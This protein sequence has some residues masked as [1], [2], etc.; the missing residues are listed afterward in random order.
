MKSVQAK[1]PLAASMSDIPPTI[2]VTLPSST[3]VNGEGQHFPGNFY[4]DPL[5]SLYAKL[6][7]AACS[8]RHL[9]ELT[10]NTR[11]H[12]NRTRFDAN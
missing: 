3:A 8:T 6:P 9:G 7:S 12:L 10:H 4:D 5:C 1:E 2:A 11:E